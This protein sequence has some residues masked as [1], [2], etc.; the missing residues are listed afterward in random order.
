V[1]PQAIAF[2]LVYTGEE[3]EV[4]AQWFED[5][6][7][8]QCL[9]GIGCDGPCDC[10]AGCKFCRSFSPY[11]QDIAPEIINKHPVTMQL[12]EALEDKAKVSRYAQHLQWDVT[13]EIKSLVRKVT[14]YW[15][16]NP[17]PLP[18][19]Q[20][21]GGEDIQGYVSGAPSFSNRANPTHP[22]DVPR[23]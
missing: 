3:R 13:S 23:L 20:Q 6:F 7:C 12:I 19:L 4:D 16:I 22:V 5:F 11:E 15:V 10:N 18:G 21:Q 8:C 1:P 9:S 17:M 14:V 2:K